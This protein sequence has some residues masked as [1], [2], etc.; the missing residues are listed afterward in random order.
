MRIVNP[1]FAPND[2]LEQL[3]SA[4]LSVGTY[5]IPANGVD[6]QSP[7]AEDEIYIVTRGVARIVTPDGTVDVGTG[8]VI[9]VPAG[10]EHRFVEI[11]EDLALLVI[12]APPWRSRA[13]VTED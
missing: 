7:H 2:Y 13:Q 3:R 8:A 9:Y 6:N 1:E 12:F 5:L 11:T 4:D 10:E